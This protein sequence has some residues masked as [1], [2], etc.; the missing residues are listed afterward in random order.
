MTPTD[1]KQLATLL[2]KLHTTI[3]VDVLTIEYMADADPGDGAGWT[4]CIGDRYTYGTALDA[5]RKGVGVAES[6]S[7]VSTLTIETER[8]SEGRWI[9]EIP[10]MP[11]CLVYGATRWE[12]IRRVVELAAEVG[13]E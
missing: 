2:D 9:A 10:S 5:L 1:L 12:A 4:V 3:A 8:E 7:T 6:T 11:G 13:R